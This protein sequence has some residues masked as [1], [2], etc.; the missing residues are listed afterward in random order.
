VNPT[1]RMWRC[2]HSDSQPRVHAAA[3][4]NPKVWTNL[5][6]VGGLS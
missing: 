5:P 4:G 1:T 2:G 3:A 6:A